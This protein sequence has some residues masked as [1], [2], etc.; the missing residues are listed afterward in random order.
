MA[1]TRVVLEAKDPSDRKDYGFNWATLL[2]AEG[3]TGIDASVW[4]ASDPAGL[5][6]ESDSIVGLVTSVIVSGGVAGTTYALTNTIVTSSG[7]P[8]THERT[9]HIP[10]KDR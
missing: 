6:V 2:G 4:S 7:T 10:C 9:I 5:T 8:R 1:T 3:E